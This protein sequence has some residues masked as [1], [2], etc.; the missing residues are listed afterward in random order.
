MD[1]ATSAGYAAAVQTAALFDQQGASKIELAGPDARLFMHNLCTQDVKNLAEGAGC[2]TFLTTAKARVVAHGVASHVRWQGQLALWFDTVAGEA[3]RV[4]Q[5]L[6]HFLI[7]EQVE[8]A[9]RTGETALVQVVGPKAAASLSAVLETT[10]SA[11]QPWHHQTLPWAD[12]ELILR[13]NSALHLPAF[14][15]FCPQPI[16]PAFVERLIRQGVVPAGEEAYD[17]LRVEAGWPVYGI[18]MD[19]NRFVVEAGRNAQAISYS[20]GCFLG[21]EPIVMARDRG[22]V[23]RQ[24][25]GVLCGAGPKLAAGTRLLQGDA[26][27]GQVT[28][29]VVSPRLSQTIALAYIK[30]GSQNPGTA[31]TIDAPTGRREATVSALPFPTA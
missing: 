6:N 11:L 24:L 22:Q 30:R 7:S 25:L 10:V 1:A 20:K 12:Q 3:Q 16:K 21:Q 28:S 8:L 9:D 5:H 13:A 2:E 18:D 17:I 26:E 4:L 23:N 15:C 14:D 31:L 29:S 27:V 19:E